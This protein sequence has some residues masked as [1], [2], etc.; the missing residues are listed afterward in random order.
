MP[1]VTQDKCKT[2]D[3]LYEFAHT[4]FPGIHEIL[5]P[6]GKLKRHRECVE[7]QCVAFN[8]FFLPVLQAD[9]ESGC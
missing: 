2:F 4:N 3:A 1:I 5:P 7:Y 6:L 8:V 9:E